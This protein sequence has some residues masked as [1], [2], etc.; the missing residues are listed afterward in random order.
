MYENAIINP[1]QKVVQ[2][3]FRYSCVPIE[4]AQVQLLANQEFRE[5]ITQVE[6]FL[7][8]TVISLL[9][10]YPGSYNSFQTVLKSYTDIEMIDES[11]YNL[12]KFTNKYMGSRKVTIRKIQPPK[13]A[14]VA[15]DERTA[16]A[17]ITVPPN[18][19]GRL[20]VCLIN[21][22]HF[23]VSTQP[24]ISKYAIVQKYDFDLRF[25]KGGVAVANNIG[26]SAFDTLSLSYTLRFKIEYQ[27]S[28][29]YVKEVSQT[30]ARDATI[31]LTD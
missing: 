9:K 16:D 25:A 28:P 1:D 19:R 14:N 4:G 6:W 21:Q 11:E 13:R 15:A 23:Y 8:D 7:T 5:K 2:E 10:N 29:A 27:S 18:T 3:N 20:L 31:A 24:I 22:T 17:R 30:D 12:C 26:A